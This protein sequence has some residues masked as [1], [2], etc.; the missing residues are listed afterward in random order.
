MSDGKSA[1]SK[2]PLLPVSSHTSVQDSNYV[3][4]ASVIAAY[5]VVSI[6]MVLY[7]TCLHINIVQP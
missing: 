7:E 2:E 1:D 4:I 5:W 3:Y 6:S